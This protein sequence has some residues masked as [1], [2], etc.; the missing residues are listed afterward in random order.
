[1]VITLFDVTGSFLVRTNDY[2][3]Y[4]WLPEEISDSKLRVRIIKSL[5]DDGLT[6]ADLKD[7]V[8]QFIAQFR[9]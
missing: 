6:M 2:K 8:D 7:T 5:Y 1:V 9:T 3:Q 4:C